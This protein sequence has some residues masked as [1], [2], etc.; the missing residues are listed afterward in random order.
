MVIIGAGR[1][2]GAF[3]SRAEAVNV[4]VALVGRDQGWSA[5]EGPAGDPILVA[6][7][8]DD[9]VDVVQRTP[10]HRRADLVFM[11]NGAIRE[12]LVEMGLAGAGRGVLYVLVAT[13]GGPLQPGPADIP[14]P[15]TGPHAARVVTF[16]QAIDVPAQAVDPDQ[17]AVVEFEKLLWLSIFGL[18]CEAHDAPVGPVA[19]EHEAEVEALVRELWPVGEAAWGVQADPARIA[20]RLLVYSRSIPGCRASVKEGPYR[21]G[22][23]SAQAD[24]HGIQ[25]PLHAQWM[26]RVG[27]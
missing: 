1:I 26:V 7:R 10:E 24:A 12:S 11:Q 25:L 17:F 14:S 23:L 15:F 13:R 8:N 9:L 3:A 19:D 6:T 2:G 21:N 27:R 5:L 16:L 22:W 20:E 18:L 4:P